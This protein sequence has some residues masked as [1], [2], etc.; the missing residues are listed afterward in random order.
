MGEIVNL[1]LVRKRKARDEKEA[2]AS[3]NR[4]IFGRT[5]AEKQKVEAE[6]ALAERKIEGHKRE[7]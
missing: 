3:E 4:I 6:R 2:K 7:E 5:K 1:K